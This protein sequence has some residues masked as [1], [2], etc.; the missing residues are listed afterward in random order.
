MWERLAYVVDLSAN[1]YVIQLD[2]D[3]ITRGPVPEVLDCVKSNRAFTLGTWNGQ[4]IV[5][6]IDASAYATT[7][8]SQDHI[9]IIAEKALASLTN[10]GALKY[11]RGSAGLVGLARGGFSR[12][13]V[14]DFYIQM[15][16]LVGERFSEWGTD[17]V[18]F[19]F[20]I[21]NS[22]D[23]FVLPYPDYAV[24]ESKLD[25]DRAR[26]LHFIGSNRFEGERYANEGR[27]FV[28]LAGAAA[29]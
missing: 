11:V 23:A 28:S 3:T 10:A 25:L 12:A 26:F 20:L 5:S 13:W 16:D 22:P 19:N 2:S 8:L 9:Q 4:R 14:E 18:A 27:R 15:A 29:L 1:E 7:T 6:A 17:Q 21:A 24:V